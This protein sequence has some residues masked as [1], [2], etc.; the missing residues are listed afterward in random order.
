MKFWGLGNGR[1]TWNNQ[2][3]FGSD[4]DHESDPEFF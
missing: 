4:P 1:G 2:L 3:D